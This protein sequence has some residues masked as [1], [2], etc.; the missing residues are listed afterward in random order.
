VAGDANANDNGGAQETSADL[1]T[2]ARPPQ[3][4][5]LAFDGSLNND[6]WDESRAFAKATNVKLTYFISGTYFIPDAQKR[7][8]DAPHGHGPGVSEIGW[9]GKLDA[10]KTRYQNVQAAKDD[11]HEIGSHANGHFDGSDWSEDDWNSEFDQ[12]NDIIFK[13]VGGPTPNLK[14]SAPDVIG[15]RAPQLGQDAGLYKSLVSH[16]FV[17]DTSK[18]SKSNYWPQQVDGVWNFPL[19]E[20]KIVGSGKNTLSMDYNF[21]FQQS[22]GESDPGNKDLYKKQMLDTYQQYFEQNYFGNRGP[23]HIGHHFSKWNGG[24]YWE[25]MQTF[26]KRVCGLPEV[27]CVTYRDLLSFVT[28]NKDKLASYQAGSFTKMPR[29]PSAEEPVDITPSFTDEELHEMLAAHAHNDDG[30]G[31]DD[32]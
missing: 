26:A 28:D 6:F 11:G 22:K 15:F 3:F 29:P 1:T 17:Y 13:G 27:K 7:L 20:L 18:T 2:V 23:V 25:A 10:I 21:Y 14:F 12:F 30:T 31:S 16:G 8:Y 9:G 19:A 32:E 5:L 4:V 24:A